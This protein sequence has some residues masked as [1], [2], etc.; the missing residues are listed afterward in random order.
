MGVTA[1]G[2]NVS[3]KAGAG[4]LSNLF[5][6]LSDRLKGLYVPQGEIELVKKHLFPYL[7]R[8]E[9][10][11]ENRA[12]RAFWRALYGDHPYGWNP[13]T[14]DMA[15]VDS[16]MIEAWVGKI[17]NPENAVLTVIGDVQ[18]EEVEK[19]ANEWIGEWKGQ[20]KG[21]VPP[22]PPPASGKVTVTFP[23]SQLKLDALPDG[24]RTLVIHRPGATQ[25]EFRLGCILPPG[26]DFAATRYRL[27]SL[28]A[29]QHLFR[30][31]RQE[32]GATYGMHGYAQTLRGGTSHLIIFGNINNAR[33]A[34]AL[35]TIK[36]YWDGL[37]RGEFDEREAN[38][39]QWDLAAAYHMGYSTTGDFTSAISNTWNHGWPLESID[40]Y[41]DKVL[42]V[43][44]EEMQKAFATCH[45]NA[46]LSIVG[47]E[48]TIR[49]ALTQG[50]K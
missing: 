49:A 44:K 27:M 4:N 13:T 47:D 14:D 5:A 28:M 45:E 46:V 11:A 19:L 43:N 35:T 30:Q 29:S 41:G 31:V 20:S 9:N 36:R 32:L 8:L 26:D 15:K 6:M 3:M 7:K 42:A 48:P 10:L 17:M 50:W 24:I 38:N 16:R 1:D 12:D 37:P 39:S 23:D 34:P 40:K 25:A 18:P 33:L 21:E 2:F 22:V